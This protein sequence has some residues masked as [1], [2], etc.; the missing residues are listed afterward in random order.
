MSGVNNEWVRNGLSGSSV[1]RI[2]EV[3]EKKQY[4]M[5]LKELQG[6]EEMVSSGHSLPAKM[7]VELAIHACSLIRQCNEDK[8][9]FEEQI[10]RSKKNRDSIIQ[11]LSK[12]IDQLKRWVERTAV[13]TSQSDVERQHP[14]SEY[15]RINH[16][17]EC[18]QLLLHGDIS[19]VSSTPSQDGNSTAE[20]SI[21]DLEA[22][23]DQDDE[24]PCE[25]ISDQN[26][27]DEGVLDVRMF[28]GFRLGKDESRKLVTLRGKGGQ[29]LRYLL[30]NRSVLTPKEVLME[31]FWP[32]HDIESARN[33]LN[34]AVYGLRKAFRKAG[35]KKQSIVFMDGGY[36]IN[37]EL[38]LTIDIE[39]FNKLIAKAVK[40]EAQGN[41]LAAARGYQK[42]ES[43]YK[44]DFLTDDLYEE[45]T[46]DIRQSLK[47]KYVLTLNKLLDHSY[48][49]KDFNLA[50][51]FGKKLLLI[52]AC[53]ENANRV[54]MESYASLGQRHLALR[55]YNICKSSL[56]SDM[57]LEAGE[58]MTRLYNKI[59]KGMWNQ[60]VAHVMPKRA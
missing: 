35:L 47:E 57:G 33:N 32:N 44:G 34:V 26:A 5:V 48:R 14:H 60:S 9:F 24:G 51:G 52:D 13:N 45:W 30:V 40:E 28:G 12:I 54:I 49:M 42:A 17:I 18:I 43:S 27:I 23:V 21:P 38:P 39:E 29:L 58:E 20:A 36:Q 11:H 31:W 50:I 8:T 7:M 55:Q 1:A 56:A 37:N 10:L 22:C 16:S 59:K 4:V 41:E 53:D 25:S 3:A 19:R 2:R 15:C 6:L 46:Q